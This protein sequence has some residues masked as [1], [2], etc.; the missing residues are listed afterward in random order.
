MPTCKFSGYRGRPGGRGSCR[1]AESMRAPTSRL[2]GSFA[3]PMIIGAKKLCD[4]A[5]SGFDL[6][7]EKM[8]EVGRLSAYFGQFELPFDTARIAVV[9]RFVSVGNDETF[10]LRPGISV[11]HDQIRGI[12]AIVHGPAGFPKRS[13]KHRFTSELRTI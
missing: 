7:L 12:S 9:R 6:N 1:A 10:G 3:F 2:S 4:R 8:H 5:G 13:R 11:W